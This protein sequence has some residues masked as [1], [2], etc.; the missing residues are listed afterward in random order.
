MLF[1]KLLLSLGWKK[2][3]I[4]ANAE[5]ILEECQRI[6]EWKILLPAE[7]FELFTDKKNI[8]IKDNSLSAESTEEK[9]PRCCKDSMVREIKS[10]EMFCS[11]CGF[12]RKKDL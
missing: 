5:I 3:K 4:I 8:E 6:K 7:E 1:Q 9:C 12:G 11:R 10:G 2:E